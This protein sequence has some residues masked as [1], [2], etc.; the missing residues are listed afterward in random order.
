MI[1]LTNINDLDDSKILYYKQPKR[2]AVVYSDII[3]TFDIEVSSLFN[4]NGKWQNFDYSIEDYTEIEKQSCVYISMFGIE[5]KVYYFRDFKFFE[6][7]LK[8]LSNP[9]AR[10]IIYIHNLSYEFQFLR[11]ILKNYTIENMLATAPHK[12]ISFVVKELN[13]EFRCSYRLTNLSLEKSAEKYTNVRKKSGDL[14]YNIVRSPLTKLTEKELGYCEYDIITLYEII[15]HFRTEYKHTCLIPL[16]QTGEVRRELKKR[17][18]FPYIKRI[19]SLIPD[20]MTSL[21]LMQAF[22]GGI[23]HSNMIYTGRVLNNIYSA[24]ESSA[25]PTMLL[26]KKYPCGKWYEY[27]LQDYEFFK[28]DK[29]FIFH[30]KIKGLK[31]KLLNHYISSNKFIT[32]KNV[33][34]DNGRVVKAD[35]IELIICD[36]DYENILLSYNYTEIEYIKI[37]GANKNYLPKE[38]LKFILE[39]YKAKT[40]LKGIPEQEDFYMKSKQ[41]INSIYGCACTSIFNQDTIF[42][43]NEWDK[44]IKDNASKR[45]FITKKLA[46][47][48]NSFS[49]IF[50]YSTGVYCTAYNRNAL[51]SQIAKNDKYV[52]Y[53]DTDSIKSTYEIDYT[54]YNNKIIAECEQSAK[55]ND[56]DINAFKPKTI[57]G[58]EKQLGIFE[59]EPDNF[60]KEFITLGAKKYCYRTIDNKLHLTVSGIRKE[61]VTGL[62]DNINNF[63]I[64]LKFD[65]KTAKK[66]THYY[67]EQ[68]PFTFTDVD[69]NT[70]TCTDEYGIVLA[71]T[72]YTLG[73]S[74][75]YEKLLNYLGDLQNE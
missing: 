46:E 75:D 2:N 24:D 29:A 51:W 14:D 16:T 30:I 12:P 65:Y 41:Q 19:Q 70:F 11:M 10:K 55:I 45:E 58:I 57:K 68:I 47:Q 64:G 38:I 7:I 66:N 40:E 52:V 26:T 69:G 18:S 20:Y 50:L 9:R 72:T 5:D 36:T 43:N 37:L 15:K 56:L 33:Y 32:S 34:R 62:K 3:Y 61:A 25:Y 27:T 42:I 53:Y 31:S 4:I 44:I 17:V 60:G 39:L 13:I 63:K 6:E 21:Y 35:E 54:E 22:Q 49:S 67:T 74:D 8:K 59:K 71:P 73:L 28:D 23:T 48:R 1:E